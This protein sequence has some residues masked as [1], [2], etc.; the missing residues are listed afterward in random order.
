MR[1]GCSAM[2]LAFVIALAMCCACAQSPSIAPAD[3]P[4]NSTR[5][6]SVRLD[7]RH[8]NATQLRFHVSLEN[9]SVPCSPVWIDP[10]YYPTT[11][12]SRPALVLQFQFRREGSGETAPA[13]PSQQ[14]ELTTPKPADFLLLDCGQT[15]G[16]FVE[17]PDP[18]LRWNYRLS[19]G[20]YAVRAC[21][22]SSLASDLRDDDE[23]ARAFDVQRVRGSLRL[24]EAVRDFNAC[25]AWTEVTRY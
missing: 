5:A 1:E 2:R 18:L 19:P 8:Q 23:L 16:R 10:V 15:F 12:A 7:I 20:T 25:S 17:L 3:P 14:W 24:R 22:Q 6:P 11:P 21:V 13:L 9:D 4:R